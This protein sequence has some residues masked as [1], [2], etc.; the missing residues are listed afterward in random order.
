M[1]FAKTDNLYWL[2]LLLPLAVAW[3]SYEVWRRGV[4]RRLGDLPLIEAMTAS[5]NPTRKLAARI[6]QL[7]ALVLL[8]IALAQPQW[9]ISDAP[10][11]REGLDVVFAMDLSRSMLAEDVAPNRLEAANREIQTFM[12]R[13]AGDRVGLVIFTSLSFPQ[14]P[15]TTDYAA[16]NFFLRR[17]HPEQIPV[18][19]TSLG[20]ALVDAIELLTGRAEDP[21]AE[22]AMARS[23]NQ[24]IVLITDG[25]DHESDP[26]AAARR[27]REL[28]IR[29][30]TVGVGSTEGAR[31][32][33][34]DQYGSRR[35]YLRDR[36]GEYVVSTLDDA[37]LKKIAQTTGGTYIHF[38]R[39]GAVS[40]ALVGFLD[41]LERTQFEDQLRE[42]Y[43]DRF[44]IFLVPA[45]L[46]TLLSIFLGQ[47]VLPTVGAGSPGGRLG[48]RVRAILGLSLITLLLGASGCEPPP[49]PDAAIEE[50]NQLIDQGEFQ[51]ALDL[52]EP[53]ASTYDDR[54]EFHYN[55]GRALLGLE[56]FEGAREAFARA[57]TVDD[58]EF[59]AAILYNL[60]L[61][62]AGL[63]EWREAHDAFRQGLKLF[64]TV[65]EPEDPELGEALRHN[66][67]VALRALYPP[68]ATF[69]DELEPNDDPQNAHTLE[70]PT[71]KDLTLCGENI[72]LF[73]IDAVPG[74]L[75]GVSA[76]FKEVREEPDP[77]R[78]F[79]TEPGALRLSILAPDGQTV[80]AIDEG[81]DDDDEALRGQ[82]ARGEVERAIEEIVLSQQ[83]LGSPRA[84]PVF[85]AVETDPG[86][87]FA[88]E[89]D[90]HFVPP[91]EALQEESEPN[92]SAGAAARL[93]GNEHQ[94]QLCKGD[95]DWFTFKIDN[96]E[97]LFVDLQ[98]QPD[99]ESEDPPQLTLEVRNAASGELLARGLPAGN[100]LSAGIPEL[101][102]VDEVIVAITGVDEAQQGPY[103]LNFFPFA[104]CPSGNDAHWPNNSPDEPATLSEE[105]QE[106]RYARIC[107]D[108][109]DFFSVPVPED[110]PLQW[111]IS[112]IP[113]E[114]WKLDADPAS[115]L[116][117]GPFP[118]HTLSHVDPVIGEDLMVAER[119]ESAP[120]APAAAANSPG[121]TDAENTPPALAALTLDQGFAIE[122][123]DDERA[124]LK[125][126]GEPGFYHLQNLN[127][128][129][130]GGSDSQ[131]QQEQQDQ[132]QNQDQQEDQQESDDQQQQDPQ[133]QEDGEQQQDESEA[134][135]N[136]EQAS[137]EPQEAQPQPSEE[138][139]DEE[140]QELMEI[141]RALE[142]SDDNF[143]LKKSLQDVP[144][145]HIEKDW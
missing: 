145:R 67:E 25:E 91:C 58:P 120:S 80:L 48:A 74:S 128:G 17:V 141:L 44:M 124:V 52:M 121:N 64:A 61:S 86:L 36:D 60:G 116:P 100:R 115:E 71:L 40:N 62:L 136:E 113:Q 55:R 132:Q 57:L 72:D 78:V 5:F 1:V 81:L 54:P 144:R 118:T 92:N 47:R 23:P 3:V 68:C 14:A 28:G 37:M 126:T 76:T 33:V 79:L 39:P 45:F 125:V 104:A 43:I 89:L 65:E 12:T 26:M 130:S 15:L 11:S 88:Y 82:N 143:Q 50:A 9:G 10:S 114:A 22:G 119:P 83:L 16:I 75:L 108:E 30:V 19:G 70:E 139:T 27:A 8:A 137:E 56:D 87:E 69:E 2:A 122:D 63:E 20:A 94:L 107:P 66:L 7:T 133:E 105:Q 96:A 131:D 41:Q 97:T 4:I 135:Q 142:E 123:L 90:V 112:S 18:G 13:L 93:E 127:G 138:P 49:R 129:G 38:D 59:R 6:C 34:F 42:R 35:G 103:T 77:E 111:G 99:L 53:L 84:A 140:R 32:P 110:E 98:P 21:E 109:A 106:V 51:Q 29:V 102:E 46:L 95:E 134:P 101:G 31:V 85:I 73:K 117:Y 24:V